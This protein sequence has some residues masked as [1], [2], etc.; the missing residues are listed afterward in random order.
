M[1]EGLSRE[2]ALNIFPYKYFSN[3]QK[4]SQICQK[5]SQNWDFTNFMKFSQSLKISQI[6]GIFQRSHMNGSGILQKFH[7]YEKDL[8]DSPEIP[9]ISAIFKDSPRISQFFKSVHKLSK[10]S[11]IR[12]NIHI[13]ARFEKN[14]LGCPRISH[15]DWWVIKRFHTHSFEIFDGF[16]WFYRF[17]KDFT[18]FRVIS[19][20]F[21]RFTKNAAHLKFRDFV[22]C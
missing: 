9:Q 20:I 8:K 21:H 7:R 12:R 14:T 3:L 5:T 2:Y 17:F 16:E 13:F 10:I 22:K 15:S 4:L 18:V 1:H 11:H 6:L 19:E